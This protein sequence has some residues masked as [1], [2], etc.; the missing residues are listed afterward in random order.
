MLWINYKAALCE[1]IL[2][3]Y[4]NICNIIND[5][6]KQEALK[7]LDSCLQLNAKSIK[8][9]FFMPLYLGSSGFLNIPNDELN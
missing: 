4:Y 1:N 5:T 6:I 8:D 2:Y 3:N 9:F 7:H